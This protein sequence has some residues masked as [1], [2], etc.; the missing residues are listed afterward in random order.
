MS[1]V[2]K[3]LPPLVSGTLFGAG[4]ALGGMTDPARVIGFLDIFGRWDP[5]L[6]FVMGAA[7]AVMAVAWLAR[8]GME[9][10]VF[11]PKFWLP[12]RQI[13]RAHV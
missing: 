10:P 9:R 2:S 6:V 1:A 8:R 4:L 13:G 7:S 5:T 12:T 3:Y 11:A